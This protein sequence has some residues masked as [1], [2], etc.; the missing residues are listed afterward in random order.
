[1]EIALDRIDDERN[2]PPVTEGQTG[3]TTTTPSTASPPPVVNKP[4]PPLPPTPNSGLSDVTVS[5]S[6]TKLTVWD[7][8]TEDLDRV[9][10][11]LNGQVVKAN[12]TLMKAKQALTL[13]LQQGINTLSVKALDEGDPEINKRLNL[14]RGNAAAVEIEGV[15]VGKRSQSWNL[16]TGQTG[17][18][19]ITYQPE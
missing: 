8:G 1:M 17:T 16:M 15:V 4:N 2:K 14:P 3:G 5:V 13:Y 9:S 7:H 12:V 19:Q 18:M 6:P 10:I 11:S